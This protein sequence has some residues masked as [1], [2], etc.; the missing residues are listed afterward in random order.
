MNLVAK[1]SKQVAIARYTGPLK[2]M[3]GQRILALVDDENLMLSARDRGYRLSYDTLGSLI[4]QTSKTCAL[5]TIFSCKRG[6]ERRSAYFARRGWVVHTRDIQVVQTPQG[7]KR[8]ANAD[9]R[10]LFLAGHL[11]SRSNADVIL[12]GSGDGDLVCELAMAVAELPKPRVVM[13]MSL[14]GSTSYR[15][16]ATRNPYIAHNI[17]IGL[18]CLRPIRTWR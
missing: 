9:S 8:L 14:A 7:K 18:D 16:D 17:E 4:Q 11:V 6:E 10:I 5:H 3:R 2:P 12:I 1:N 15:L 13:T